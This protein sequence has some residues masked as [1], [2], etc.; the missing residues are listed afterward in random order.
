MSSNLLLQVGQFHFP[1]RS[2]VIIS[3]ATTEMPAIWCTFDQ[4]GYWM[5]AGRSLDQ[6]VRTPY[7]IPLLQVGWG[8]FKL[9]GPK[10]GSWQVK[11]YKKEALVNK[12]EF[13]QFLSRTTVFY[14]LLQIVSFFCAVSF[15]H[16][17]LRNRLFLVIYLY[18]VYK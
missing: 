4:C 7:S 5:G 10:S 6:F 17:D 18:R 16:D 3:A 14:N 15:I 8:C 2:K 11:L 12:F 13:K 9:K 1:I